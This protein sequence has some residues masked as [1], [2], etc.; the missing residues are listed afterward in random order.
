MNGRKRHDY[1]IYFDYWILF[2]IKYC[3]AIGEQS[4]E[5]GIKMLEMICGVVI[6]VAGVFFGA[7]LY[8]AGI[9]A[10]EKNGTNS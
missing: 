3:S 7:G 10:G 1:F 5:G 6:F 8:A 2:R 9:K 4:Y